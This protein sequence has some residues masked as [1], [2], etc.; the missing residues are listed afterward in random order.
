MSAIADT[1]KRASTREPRSEVAV[2]TQR[3]RALVH[4]RRLHPLRLIASARAGGLQ[5]RTR[6]PPE[7]GLLL[8][9]LMPSGPRPHAPV[10][11]RHRQRDLLQGGDARQV[12]VAAVEL[13]AVVARYG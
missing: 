5:F 12:Q 2:V 6:L 3:R 7:S 1:E 8:G 13:L 10:V 9:R 11:R 4:V